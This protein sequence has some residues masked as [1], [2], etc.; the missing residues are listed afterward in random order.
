[1]PIFQPTLGT[2]RTAVID[3][4]RL[5]D[6]LDVARVDEWINVA[7]SRVV[8]ETACLQTSGV[9]TLTGDEEAY[10]MP[11]QVAFIIAVVIQYADGTISNPMTR[12]SL[13]EFINYR[14]QNSIAG[15]RV[16]SPIYAIV[17]QNRMEIWP[18]P[19]ATDS[20]RFWYVYLPNALVEDGDEPVIMEPYGGKLLELGACVEGAKFKKDPL[21]RQFTDENSIWMGRFQAWLNRRKTGGP[22]AFRL[23][24]SDTREPVSLARDVG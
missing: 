12:V 5:D 16:A 24:L 2:I 21:L 19:A 9:A 14:R 6:E 18:T 10:L 15:D 4:L 11:W 1:M 3:K 20:I 7:Y 17:G 22:Q 13:D 23:I 8:Q